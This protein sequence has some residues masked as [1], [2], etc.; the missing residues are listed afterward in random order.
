[1]L[2]L[3]L[4]T[5][6]LVFLDLETTGLHP[7]QGDRICEVALQ[8]VV[9]DRVEATLDQLVNPGRPLSDAA[10]DINGIGPEQ[11]A[12]APDFAA[13]ANSLLERFAGAAL[14]AHNASFDVEFIRAELALIDGSLPPILAID[15]LA[16]ARRLIP[17]RRSYSL[18]ALTMALGGVPPVH[19]AM[20]DVLA[21]RL[22]FDDLAQ[23]LEALGITTLGDTL[24]FARGFSPGEP[25]PL[26]PPQIAAALND[27]RLL[28]IVYTSVKSPLPI[29][30]VIRPLDLI[31]ERGVLYLRAYCF[32][33]DDLRA[34]VIDKIQSIEIEN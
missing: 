3:P 15:T 22:V 30:R 8:R 4:R 27:G 14:V 24:R 1:M 28:R 23:R 32:L 5:V 31:R 19:R 13:I 21:L 26:S 10:F 18:A 2:D 6:P 20:A 25:E 16:L 9:G 29:E 7:H 12:D 34:F 33:R 11:L 17:H